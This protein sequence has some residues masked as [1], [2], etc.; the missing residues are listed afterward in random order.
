MLNSDGVNVDNE[1]LIALAK[2][3]FLTSGHTLTNIAAIN[4]KWDN[5]NMTKRTACP[6][7]WKETQLLYFQTFYFY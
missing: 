3:A 2:E 1:S 5:K 6:D 7:T 4:I